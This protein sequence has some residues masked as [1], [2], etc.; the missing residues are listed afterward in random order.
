MW[1]EKCEKNEVGEMRVRRRDARIKF[2]ALGIFA[3]VFLFTF[4]TQHF[5]KLDDG[6]EAASLANFDPGYIISD[7]QMGNY[8]SMSEAEIQA[9][10]TAKNSCSNTNYNTYLQ[11][12]ANTKYKW[13]WENGHFVCLSE[14]LF[15]DGEIIGS[16]DTAAHIIWQ[17][18]QDYKINPQVLLVL[19]QK[20][21]GLITDKIPNDGDY[22]KAT[23]YGCPDTA[24]CSSQYYGFKNQIRKAAALFRTVL[25]GGWTNYPLGNN[26]IQYNPNADCGGSVVNIRSLATSALYRYTPY[27]PN[28]GA[29]AA[30]YGTAYCGAYGNR[31]FY[32]YFE[33]W[34]G[35]VTDEYSAKLGRTIPDG[36]YQ[37][38]SKKYEKRAL[39]IYGGIRTGMDSEKVILYGLKNDERLN[40]T[41]EVKYDDASGFYN[42]YNGASSLYFE[43]EGDDLRVNKK[44]KACGQYW[45]IKRQNNN[46]ELISSCD[47][48]KIASAS[49][50]ELKFSSGI[51]Q[52]ETLWKMSEI[53]GK[54]NVLKDGIYQISPAISDELVMDI[55]GGV[56]KNSSSGEIILWP[57]RVKNK[58]EENQKFEIK[59][60]SETG[61]Y[62][63]INP[64]S[65]LSLDVYNNDVADGTKIIAWKINS[66]CN[67]Q[68]MLRNSEDGYEIISMCTGKALDVPN[69]NAVSG[70]DVIL[71][72]RQR[73]KNQKW[74]FEEVVDEEKS[75]IEEDRD[76]I[77]STSKNS[78]MVLD[79]SGGVNKNMIFGKTIIYGKKRQNNSN[80]IFRFKKDESTGFYYIYNPFSR[81][82]LDVENG[83]YLDG[84]R[85]ILWPYNGGCNQKWNIDE[86]GDGSFK[87]TSACSKKVMDLSGGSIINSTPI[88]IYGWHDGYNQ[89]WLITKA[90][91]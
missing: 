20:E 54:T 3:A 29:L 48:K 46:Y 55:K 47:G 70:Q 7:Y 60:N 10:L 61:Y 72:K 4:L 65:G 53:S 1:T 28:A 40:Q 44:N 33:D 56:D 23:G 6:V 59:Y 18:A 87:L 71:Y 24:P 9:F 35:G 91:S 67:Q 50:D 36:T 77:I 74:I 57:K 27:Q 45:N 90:N 13:H 86:I 73:S 41:F 2:F 64:F 42:I 5:K 81:L 32:L 14:E 78:E 51:G 84:T 69:S 63:I 75:F 58:Y 43:M 15:G 11:L 26:Y 30:G 17:A 39:D 85:V 38:I 12:S 16:G 37:I 22:R 8:N 21:T 89:K 82:Y 62:T 34:F 88:I 76:F 83:N 31:N 79:I 80:Q 19:L 52:D 49:E 68:W 25:D 66:G